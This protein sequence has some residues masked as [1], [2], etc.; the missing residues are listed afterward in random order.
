MK[1]KIFLSGHEVKGPKLS[2]RAIKVNNER[3]IFRH[4]DQIAEGAPADDLADHLDQTKDDLDVTDLFN[5]DGQ[6][7]LHRAAD[8]N[9]HLA[10]ET[11]ISFFKKTHYDVV[12]KLSLDEWVNQ[13]TANREGFASLHLAVFNGNLPLM[14]L[15]IKSGADVHRTNPM[16]INALH[17][18]A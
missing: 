6:N 11:L 16:G 1:D 18:A 7:P 14:R 10:A 9:C 13:S 17:L 15:L 12:F 4:I 8:K 2:S 5:Q 3:L